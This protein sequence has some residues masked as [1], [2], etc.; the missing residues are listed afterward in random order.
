MPDLTTAG[1]YITTAVPG[2]FFV[3]TSVSPFSFG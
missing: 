1:V 2:F 3:L